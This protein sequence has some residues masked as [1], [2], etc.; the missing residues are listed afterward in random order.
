MQVET[1][2]QEKRYYDMASKLAQFQ[3][4]C[5]VISVFHNLMDARWWR[6]VAIEMHVCKLSKGLKKLGFG[7]NNVNVHGVHPSSYGCTWEELES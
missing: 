1:E 5:L 4:I 3:A 2:Y 7:E 6:N